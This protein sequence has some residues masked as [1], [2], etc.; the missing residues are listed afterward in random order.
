M[1]FNSVEE[2]VLKAIIDN[3]EYADMC[4]VDAVTAFFDKEGQRDTARFRCGAGSN[5]P[6]GEFVTK[7]QRKKRTHPTCMACKMVY[8]NRQCGMAGYCNLCRSIMSTLI[9]AHGMPLKE[10]TNDTSAA[11]SGKADPE[12]R[13]T[14]QKPEQQR[15]SGLVG[16]RKSFGG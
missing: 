5:C 10:G 8:H 13:S 16:N 2:Y 9:V 11:K 15:R 1:S 7:E 14:P 6:Y 12:R 4:A 3:S